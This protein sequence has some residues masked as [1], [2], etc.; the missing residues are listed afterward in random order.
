MIRII[1]D[2]NLVVSGLAFG[3]IPRE[4]LNGFTRRKFK[5][6]I[7]HEILNEHV[8]VVTRISDQYE[9][10]GALKALESLVA[11]AELSFSIILKESV[12]T[13]PPD[14]KFFATAKAADVNIIVNGNTHLKNASGW[15]GIHVYSPAAP[16]RP[17]SPVPSCPMPP[18]PA[19]P[20]QQRFR[21]TGRVRAAGTG[22][23]GFFCR[24]TAS[25]TPRHRERFSSP[26]ACRAETA[27]SGSIA[28]RIPSRHRRT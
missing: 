16:P 6:V 13:D 8:E 7:S 4:I 12:C 5:M 14:D 2:T 22:D 28:R 11:Q 20:A 3:G 27:S 21:D 10:A 24:G 15:S 19:F 26:A 1:L 9:I 18:R 25:G 23:Q 17:T